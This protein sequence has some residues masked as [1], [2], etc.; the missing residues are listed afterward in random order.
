MFLMK[1]TMKFVS[2]TC[3]TVIMNL[4]PHLCMPPILD[5]ISAVHPSRKASIYIYTVYPAVGIYYNS[6]C[7][8]SYLYPFTLSMEVLKL[9][10]KA[11]QLG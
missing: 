6:Y 4:K 10:D 2:T 5:V 1:H 3:P 8:R 11:K 9:A 7:I